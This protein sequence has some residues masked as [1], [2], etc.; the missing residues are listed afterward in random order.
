MAA[1]DLDQNFEVLEN[2]LMRAWMHRDARDVKALVS[3]DFIFMFGTKPPVLLDRPSF[4]A[5][6]EDRFVCEGFRFQEVTARKYGKSVW[7]SGHVE[8]ELRVGQHKWAG[9]FLIT[10]LWRKSAIR[11]R[12]MLAERSL[13]PVEND[14]R[15]SDAIRAMQ[16]WR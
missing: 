5:G 7:F 4:I 15:L 14:S 3:G 9:N 12:W 10:D 8:L 11:R 16:L 6:L 13:A 1:A 2:R